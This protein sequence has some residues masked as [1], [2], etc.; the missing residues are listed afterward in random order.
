MPPAAGRRLSEGFPAKLSTAEGLL[1]PSCPQP[2]SADD[3]VTMHRWLA[4]VTV[5]EPQVWGQLLQV[6]DPEA[7]QEIFA[8]LA[9]YEPFR[10]LCEAYE[11]TA[12]HFCGADFPPLRFKKTKATR[13]ALNGKEAKLKKVAKQSEFS[14][15]TLWSCGRVLGS[16]SASSS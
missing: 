2:S 5:V 8:R 3:L 14:G 6:S 10:N 9:S 1:S 4:T 12:R 16:L 13:S 7:V 15:L 11:S